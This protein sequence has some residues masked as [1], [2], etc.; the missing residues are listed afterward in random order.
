MIKNAG[1][2]SVLACTDT[3]WGGLGIVPAVIKTVTE[4]LGIVPAGIET[5][6]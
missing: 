5:V 4:S 6:P 2:V 3:V 1:C